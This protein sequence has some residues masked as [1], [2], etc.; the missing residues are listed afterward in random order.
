MRSFGS[1]FLFFFFCTASLFG[2]KT[3]TLT[4]ILLDKADNEPIIAASVELLTAKDSAFVAGDISDSRGS[5]SFKKPSQGR[6]VIKVTYLGYLTLKQS[7]TIDGAGNSV[8]L[9]KIYMQTNDILLKEA[10]VEGKRPEVI[11]K[12]DTIEY[13]AASYKTSENA[14]VEDLLKKLPGVEVDKDGKITVNGKEIKKFM[15]DGKE[16]F[17]DDPQVASKNLPAAM[18]EKLQVVDQKS[19]MARMTGFDDGQEETIINITIRPGMKQGTMGNALAGGGSD[20]TADPDLRYQAAAF[21]N[22]MKDSDRY[23]LIIGSN[24]N[25]NMGAADLGANSFG[26]MRMRRGGGGGGGIA[27]TDNF[28]FSLNKALSKTWTLNSDIRYTGSDR[29]SLSNVEEYTTLLGNQSQL[30]KT[31]TTTDYLSRSLAANFKLDWKPDKFN[32]L[33]FRPTVQYNMSRSDETEFAGRW[34]YATMDSIFKSDS[35]SDNHGQGFNF[36]GTLDYSHQFAKEGR[37]FSISAKTTYNTSN[38]YENAMTHIDKF[39]ES[40]GLPNSLN[41]RNENDN[42][43]GQYKA[44]VS[45]VEPLGKNYFMQALYRISYYDTK[46]INSTYNLWNQLWGDDQD[47]MFSLAADSAYLVPNLSRSTERNVLEQ[48]AGLSLKSVHA[49]YNYT[50]GLNLDPS[51]ST[52]ITYQ[53]SESQVQLLSFLYDKRLPNV[54]GDLPVDTVKQDVVNVSPVVNFV[55]NFGTRTNLRVDYEGETNQPSATQLRDYTDMS[56]PTNWMKG[57]PNLK[58]GYSNSLRVRYSKYVQDTQLMYNLGLNANWMLNDI[59]SVTQ[60]VDTVIRQTTYENVNGNWNAQLR[61]M[62]SMPLRNKRF[63][64]SSFA[65]TRYQNLN[66]Y[67]L[68]DEQTLKNTMKNFSIRDNS[69]IN[70]RSD[71]FDVG[72]NVSMN[73]SNVNYSVQP[74][75]N[76]RTLSWGIGGNT[77]WYLPHNL[78]LESDITWTK[79]SG[80]AGGF[81]LPETIWNFAATKQLFNKKIGTGSLKLQIFD[82]L[83]DRKNI[84]SSATTNGYR[85]TEVN[86]ISSYFMLSFIYKFTV[87]PKG[88]SATEEDMRSNNQ[89][90]RPDGRPGPPPSGPPPGGAPPM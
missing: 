18:V 54:M 16:F 62:F 30:D 78:V 81:N 14:V 82:L 2:Q 90:N 47:L 66:S 49:K 6:Y 83:Q 38:A 9:G 13:D 44:T 21:V 87:F 25:N 4:G 17:S 37:V 77:A 60:M 19:D 89:W 24:N 67:L 40:P 46:S 73:Y 3:N 63:T 35:K 8:N 75:N 48:R 23:T 56:R 57:N 80:F 29:L 84:T 42:R 5:F 11:V 33:T 39:V 10:V 53:P 52:N 45:W 50:V 74:E 22:H 71:L 70:Y 55:Y 65:M 26:N 85:T 86:A 12:N 59:T 79:R 68:E 58:P 31:K 20:L 76:Q 51:R 69:S 34:N 36:G 32:L 27:T 41:Q 61:G 7:I 28:M 64:I 43:S 15:V 72:L 1:L 88:S